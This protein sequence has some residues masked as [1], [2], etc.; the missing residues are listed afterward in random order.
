MGSTARHTSAKFRTLVSMAEA[1]NEKLLGLVFQPQLQIGLELGAVRN[2]LQELR[3]HNEQ[4][5]VLRAG[6]GC[7]GHAVSWWQ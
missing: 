4:R 1:L 3:Q 7:N 5:L 6:L 2:G